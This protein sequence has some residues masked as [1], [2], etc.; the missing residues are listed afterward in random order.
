[1]PA[2][3]AAGQEGAEASVI[4]STDNHYILVSASLLSILLYHLLVLV[5]PY[6][7]LSFSVFS[8][9]Y[10]LSL[11]LPPHVRVSDV[12][13]SSVVLDKIS[14]KNQQRGAQNKCNA[15]KKQKLQLVIVA[16][17]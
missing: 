12:R 15:L 3:D 6:P 16:V 14:A 7:P 8:L 4:K 5:S 11:S 13:P 9:S 2:L 1:V 17:F 10:F